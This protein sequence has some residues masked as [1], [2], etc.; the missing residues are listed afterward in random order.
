MTLRIVM[1]VERMLYGAG[2]VVGNDRRRIPGCNR[3]AERVGI[4]GRIGHDEVRLQ[5]F[6]KRKGLRRIARLAGGEV[7]ANG[8]AQ[9]AHGKMDFGAQA[10][11]RAADGLILSPPF[12]PLAC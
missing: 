1:G 10:A 12:A 9:A 3:I 5:T 11:A 8:T 4:I 6:D 7:K 2:W